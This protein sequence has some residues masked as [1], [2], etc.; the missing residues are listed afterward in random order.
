M[1]RLTGRD[2]SEDQVAETS[3]C[4]LA[5]QRAADRSGFTEPGCTY[6]HSSSLAW[7]CQ[8]KRRGRELLDVVVLFYKS[9]TV[10]IVTAMGVTQ[11]LL[12]CMNVMDGKPLKK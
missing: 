7:S 9:V 6:A 5:L 10:D 12:F 4:C 3:I 8:L 1:A 11:M 2:R